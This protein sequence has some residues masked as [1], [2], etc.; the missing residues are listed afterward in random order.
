MPTRAR[1]WYDYHL[2]LKDPEDPSYREVG[3]KPGT[4][5]LLD[6]C[7]LATLRT[8]TSKGL[9]DANRKAHRNTALTKNGLPSPEI[10]HHNHLLSFETRA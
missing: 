1:T 7:V 3:E 9:E 4:Y 2:A 10:P 6:T 8:S 5:F